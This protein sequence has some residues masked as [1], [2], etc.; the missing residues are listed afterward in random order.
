M[1]HTIAIR[2]H[3]HEKQRTNIMKKLIMGKIKV[4]S[5]AFIE[6]FTKQQKKDF[7]EEY[8]YDHKG[9]VIKHDKREIDPS[10]L[11]FIDSLRYL[12]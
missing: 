12:S 1:A 4:L 5:D 2:I 9:R 7:Y 3:I 6:R 8:F 10:L 11:S